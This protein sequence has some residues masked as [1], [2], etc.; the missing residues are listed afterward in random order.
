MTL[1]RPLH[2]LLPGVLRLRSASPNVDTEGVLS[3]VFDQDFL[4]CSQGFRPKRSPHT[5]LHRLREG[6]RLHGVRYVVEADLASYF[7]SVNW[8]WLRKFV[9]HRVNDGGLIRLLNKWL[10][11][12]VMENGV[13]TQMYE[14]VPQGAHI[15]TVFRHATAIGCLYRNEGRGRTMGRHYPTHWSGPWPHAHCTNGCIAICKPAYRTLVSGR[16]GAWR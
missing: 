1:A 8:D 7:D 2:A 9:R 11:A 12:G 16:L 13:V 4:E 3:A 6:M 10:K 15:R 5:A 14:G